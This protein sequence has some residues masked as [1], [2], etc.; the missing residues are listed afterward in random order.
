LVTSRYRLDSL[1]AVDAAPTLT[2][3]LLPADDA[4]RLLARRLGPAWLAADRPAAEGIIRRCQGLPLALAI[5]A[6][7][8]AAR[9]SLTRAALGEQLRLATLVG[10]EPVGDL[11]AV[12]SWS[13]H[14]L[15]PGAAR[16]FRLLSLHP[17]PTATAAEF[18]ALGGNDPSP[19]LT[20][21]TRAHVIEEIAPDRYACHDLWREYSAEMAAASE[22]PHERRAALG[23]LL[24]HAL[25]GPADLTL[26][27]PLVQRAAAAGFAAE[28]QQLARTVEAPLRLLGHWDE[29]ADAAGAA[30]GLALDPEA[31]AGLRYAL[32]EARHRLGDYTEAEKQG[33]RAAALT[34]SSQLRFAALMLLARIH[35]ATGHHEQAL[36]AAN[37]AIQLETLNPV[38]QFNA[39]GWILST[40]G[41]PEDALSLFRDAL[42]AAELRG[43]RMARAITLHNIGD[44][45]LTCGR[46]RDAITAFQAGITE[47]RAIR[48]RDGEIVLLER[49]AAAYDAAGQQRRARRTRETWTA[50]RRS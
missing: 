4:R 5:V 41:R 50:L 7:Q 23:R 14:A 28:A 19:A 1:A 27:V 29:L 20:E 9:P 46:H 48:D 17:A 24:A 36:T 21:L 39:I 8:A 42:A 44:A 35:A 13:Y 47:C 26:L 31:E 45:H 2:V 40:E 16:L 43:D 38:D 18:G 22:P 10:D 3:R 11:R 12:L 49:L 30:V 6:A 25:A 15:S 33:R 37:N 34:A 32:A